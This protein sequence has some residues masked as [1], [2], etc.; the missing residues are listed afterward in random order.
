MESTD[1]FF[2]RKILK[3]KMK[4]TVNVHLG[5]CSRTKNFSEMKRKCHYEQYKGFDNDVKTGDFRVAH[6]ATW[7]NLYIL[8]IFVFL[9]TKFVYVFVI[10]NKYSFVWFICFHKSVKITD[11]LKL[12]T[13]FQRKVLF[14]QLLG[15]KTHTSII[16]SISTF[17]LCCSL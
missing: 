15:F 9:F 13:T 10:C 6:C 17:S 4:C 12:L 1:R 5:T 8:Y 2:V 11:K 14:K 16:L 3:T 7:Q